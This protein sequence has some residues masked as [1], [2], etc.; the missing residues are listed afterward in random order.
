MRV[1]GEATLP[2]KE[3]SPGD[4]VRVRVPPP[5]PTDLVPEAMPIRIL[6]QDPDLAVIDKPAGLVVHPGG[7]HRTGT[8]VHGLLAAIP[9]L[10]GISGKERPG[11]VHRL[12]KQTSGLMIIAKNDVAHVD[13]SRQFRK[14]EV[15]KRYLA[16]VEGAPPKPV[17]VVDEPI[18]RHPVR[19]TKFAVRVGRGREARTAYEVT[20]SFRGYSAVR[21][22][23]ETGRTQQIRVHLA[24][25]GTPVLCDGMYGKRSRITL[26]EIEGVPKKKGEEPILSRQA[27]HAEAIRFRHPRGGDSLEFSSPIPEDISRTLEALRLYRRK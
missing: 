4:Q 13:I 2:K 20:E 24:S 22:H 27:L 15:Q 10:S 7:G 8:L 26:P 1:N 12:D 11:I 16:L 9:D 19:R 18:G 3:V 25:L 5:E 17:S 14:R 21:L 23:P 6:H